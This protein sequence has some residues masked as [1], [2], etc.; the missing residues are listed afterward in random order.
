MITPSEIMRRIQISK[1]KIIGS[2]F[3]EK[4]KGGVPIHDF[5]NIIC[6]FTPH[7]IFER[8]DL[9]NGAINLF[10]Q[11]DINGDGEVEWDEFV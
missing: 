8:L 5:V 3:P 7:T 1:C 6:D 11:I 9:L 2:R 4:D 10:E